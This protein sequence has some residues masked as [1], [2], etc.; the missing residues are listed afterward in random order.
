MMEHVYTIGPFVFFAT[1]M[2]FGSQWMKKN[3]ESK[4]NY[5]YALG[6]VAALGNVFAA[7]RLMFA[8]DLP[9]VDRMS[10]AFLPMVVSILIVTLIHKIPTK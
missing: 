2:V 5:L 4:K 9:F 8:T 3:P 7:I 6:V 1:I 10:H